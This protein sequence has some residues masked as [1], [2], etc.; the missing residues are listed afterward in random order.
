M[1]FLRNKNDKKTD[2]PLFIAS[3]CLVIIYVYF[4]HKSRVSVNGV[5]GVIYGWKYTLPAIF[6][7]PETKLQKKIVKSFIV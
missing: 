1:I 2:A 5:K 7:R 4:F 3:M 6:H